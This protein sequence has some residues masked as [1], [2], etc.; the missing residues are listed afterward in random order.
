MTLLILGLLLFLGTHSVRVFGE[1]PR[2]SLRARLGGLG[3]RGAYSVA[4]LAG[5][6]LIVVGYGATRDNPQIVWI[7]PIWTRHV[8]ALLTLASFVLLAAAY[9]P[10]NAIKARLHHPM[11]LGVK[12]WALSHL[13]ANGMLADILLFGGFLLWAVLSFRAARGRD[14]AAGTVYPVGR[15]GPT[16][17]A[18]VVGVVAWAVT[19]FWA[20]GVLFGVKPFGG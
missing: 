12:V 13:L 1:G 2:T 10:G 20:H 6:V 3:Y 4:S 19:A 11:V 15:A 14:R 9:V 8:A 16:L 17:V 5:L 18:V 7:A